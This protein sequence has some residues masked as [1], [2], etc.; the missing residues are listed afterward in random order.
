MKAS[1]KPCQPSVRALVLRPS[2]RIKNA[3][4]ANEPKLT[5]RRLEHIL[6][7]V[8]CDATLTLVG[9]GCERHGDALQ[10]PR[11]LGVPLLVVHGAEAFDDL[12]RSSET[13][14]R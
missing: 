8:A 14:L 1:Q 10:L 12:L 7:K 6:G 2:S 11:R 4:T 9:R 5:R 3:T 13:R